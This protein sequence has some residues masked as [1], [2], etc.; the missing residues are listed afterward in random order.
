ML[1][2]APKY[3]KEPDSLQCGQAVLAMLTDK[4]VDEII[5]LTSVTKETKLRDMFFFLLSV[6]SCFL[7]KESRSFPK[8]SFRRSHC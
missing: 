4:T 7:V 5:K 1:T 8:P 6:I 2:K 3:I